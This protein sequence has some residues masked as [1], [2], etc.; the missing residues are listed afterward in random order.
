MSHRAVYNFET[1]Q[2]NR[3]KRIMWKNNQ[4]LSGFENKETTSGSLGKFCK[5]KHGM[6]ALIEYT[7]FERQEIQK[8][9]RWN[10]INSGKGGIVIIK[11]IDRDFNKNFSLSYRSKNNKR[12]EFLSDGTI[13][14]HQ[15]I[16]LGDT[17][18]EDITMDIE[19]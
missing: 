19:W 9:Y 6:P 11:D 5:R 17:E 7:T 8:L 2:N 4:E 18:E 16:R 14:M 15:Y 13:F 3:M 10:H 12:G 1:H